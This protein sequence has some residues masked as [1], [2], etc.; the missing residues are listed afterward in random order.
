M[1]EDGIEEMTADELRGIARK[2]ETYQHIYPG[3]KEGR[4]MAIRCREVA[5]LLERTT[6][7]INK[8][9]R[10]RKSRLGPDERLPRADH[11]E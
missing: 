11:S 2:L 1:A 6:E 8:Q 10:D 9:E 5:L 4:A 7:H 3:D